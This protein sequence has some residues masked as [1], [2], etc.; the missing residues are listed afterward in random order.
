MYSLIF[1]LLL[2]YI[3]TQSW[4]YREMFADKL[5]EKL[6]NK[7][8]IVN[9]KLDVFLSLCLTGRRFGSFYL[10]LNVNSNCHLVYI[11]IY[12]VL[13]LLLLLFSLS[14]LSCSHAFYWS[15]AKWNK[16]KEKERNNWWN[17]RMC[18]RSVCVACI[19]WN[20]T[21]ASLATLL[22][23][24]SEHVHILVHGHTQSH[25]VKSKVYVR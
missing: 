21:S 8:I 15:E 7:I 2:F 22:V 5:K 18:V 1:L 6:K 25:V 24:K 17:M 23:R 16:G 19:V 20:E 14:F 13:L 11:Y 10:R 9:I 4:I 12:H 3:Y